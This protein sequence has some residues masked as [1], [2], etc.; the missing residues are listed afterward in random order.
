MTPERRYPQVGD[1]AYHKSGLDPREVVGVLETE[2]VLQVC[3]D[4]LGENI[5]VPAINYDFTEE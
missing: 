4:V 3:I 1:W 5:W 2:G